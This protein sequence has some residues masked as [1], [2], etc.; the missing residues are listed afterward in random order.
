MRPGISPLWKRENVIGI[1]ISAVTRRA[2]S[3]ARSSS[4]AAR[5]SSEFGPVRGVGTGPGARVE[6]VPGRADGDLDILFHRRGSGA[7][8]LLRG[9]VGH[10]NRVGTSRG[11]KTAV[12][13]YVP[14]LEQKGP[15]GQRG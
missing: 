5:R 1:P 4:A 10:G 2:M 7:D 14:V 12:G 11:K 9:R 3:S 15:P 8:D 13:V 6:C